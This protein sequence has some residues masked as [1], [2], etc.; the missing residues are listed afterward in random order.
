MD[1]LNE[2]LQELGI[3]K[4][5][6]AK[7]L[8][9]SRQMIYNYLDLESLNKWPK[10]KKALL[11]KLLNIKNGDIDTIKNIKITSE[12]MEE[13]ETRLNMSIKDP[14]VVDQ[15]F[16][17]SNLS[18]EEQSLVNDLIFLIKEK[19]TEDKNKDTY[20]TFLYLYNTLKS[21]DNVPEIK[22]LF[23]YLSKKTGFTD[24][25]EFKFNETAQFM[26]ESIIFTAFNLYSNGGATKSKLVESHNRFV[27][28]IEDEKEEQLSRTQQYTTVR[29]Q[30][31]KEL[32][33][34]E[35]NNSNASEV[36]DKMA[37]IQSRKI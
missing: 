13:V 25:N 20:Y 27:Q 23:G 33:Y 31:L 11:F 16:D 2:L 34:T 22:Y 18:K 10:E 24:P 35:I 15:Y 12:Y 6:L 9:V 5:K 14:V 4:V 1:Y 8:G 36:F 28:E 26:L 21:I 37:E 17:M 29:I 19:F 32:G 3:S 7:Y 30:A